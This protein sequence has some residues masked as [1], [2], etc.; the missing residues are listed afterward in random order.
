MSQ[1][2]YQMSPGEG[3]VNTGDITVICPQSQDN[4]VKEPEVRYKV[5]GSDHPHCT[6]NEDDKDNELNND[7][8][9]S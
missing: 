5:L 8:K 1:K 4:L 2:H 3:T 7:S 6:A 9:T